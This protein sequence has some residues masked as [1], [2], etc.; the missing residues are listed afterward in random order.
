VFLYGHV[1]TP[2]LLLCLGPVM[3]FFGTGYFSGFA[4]VTAEIYETRIRATA[5][6]F[7]YNAGR[8]ASA[9]APFTV[10]SL[11]QVHGFG[12]AFAASGAAFVLAAVCWIWIPETK[13][14]A[15]V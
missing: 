12:I 5:Q 4:T 7:T 3:A 9:A 1:R 6:G 8:V 11:A 14:K 2:W 15:L 13:G 10:G